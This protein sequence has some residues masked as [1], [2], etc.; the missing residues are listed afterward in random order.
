MKPYDFFSS[1]L[2]K[3]K[4]VMSEEQIELFQEIA[5]AREEWSAAYDKF[6]YATDKD[7]VDYAIFAIEAAEKRYEMLLRRAKKLDDFEREKREA[8]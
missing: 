8:L 5:E 2:K 4:E 6:D 7:Q 3:K 1:F